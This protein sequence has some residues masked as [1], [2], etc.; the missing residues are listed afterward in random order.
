MNW[1]E[2]LVDLQTRINANFN[3]NLCASALLTSA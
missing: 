1:N 3:K 2:D